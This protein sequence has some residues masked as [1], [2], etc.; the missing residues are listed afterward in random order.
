[1]TQGYGNPGEDEINPAIQQRHKM[2]WLNE[3]VSVWPG[4]FSEK[5]TSES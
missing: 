5:R 3:R 2:R 4:S 1:M